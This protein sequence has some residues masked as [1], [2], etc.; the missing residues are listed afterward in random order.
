MTAGDWRPRL[1]AVDAD[2]T[3][4]GADEEIPAG[5]AAKLRAIEAAGV[6][7]VLVTGRSWLSA[8]LVLDQL[9]LPPSYCVCNNGATVMT[10]P[11]LAILRQET[12]D[13]APVVAAVRRHPGVIMAVEA[14][15]EGYLVS[16]P[17]PPG[18]LFELHGEIRVVSLEELASW[19]AARVLLWDPHASRTQ[20]LLFMAELPLKDLQ[21]WIDERANWL[22]LSP[23]TAGKDQGLA[24]V[25]ARLG[26]PQADTLA[27]GD[28]TN[29]IGFLRW[30]GR[31]VALGDAPAA[32]QAAADHVTGTF[33]A[34]GTLAELDK[35]FPG[36]GPLPGVVA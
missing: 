36:T 20:F 34:G 9:G 10:Y 18:G 5:L 3:I 23:G 2:G 35:W 14:F 17:L 4:L 6:P 29:D 16:Q 13:L 31:G 25:A 1:V 30:A 22:D 12:M 21:W 27:I 19:P 28:G 26:V 24:F 32:V 11:P 15:G 33:A 8:Q 7:V